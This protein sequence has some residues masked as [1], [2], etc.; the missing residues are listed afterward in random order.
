MNAPA[1][2]LEKTHHLSVT[3]RRIGTAR[4]KPECVECVWT[5]GCDSGYLSAGTEEATLQQVPLLNDALHGG[6]VIRAHLDLLA[7]WQQGSLQGVLMKHTGYR[8]SKQ[9]DCTCHR[10]LSEQQTFAQL[11]G[12]LNHA[13]LFYHYHLTWNDTFSLYNCWIF[14]S[15][16]LRIL[17][18][19]HILL[20]LVWWGKKRGVTLRFMSKWSSCRA[21]Q[22]WTYIDIHFFWQTCVHIFPVVI[23]T[24]LW[25][26]NGNE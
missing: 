2:G 11:Q 23:W 17:S 13:G 15:C 4:V 18:S 19:S 20:S 22:Q 1:P 16:V 26:K 8:I 12:L 6:R 3:M 9:H 14:S 5:H 24:Q 25:G 21:G 10:N 7:G